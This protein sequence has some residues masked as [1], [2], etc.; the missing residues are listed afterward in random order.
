MTTA[1]NSAAVEPETEPKPLRIGELSELT[2]TTPRTIRYWE[3]LGLL[4]AG[5]DRAEGKH[6]SYSRADVQRVS[7][8]IRL[9]NLLGLSLEELSSL[10]E[11]E[12]ARAHLREELSHTESPAE[13]RRILE[14]LLGHIGG[15]LELVRRR[16]RE[17]DQLAGELEDKQRLVRRRLGETER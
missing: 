12:S 13:R 4:G 8:I 14:K 2:G 11:A 6:R 15:Q 10:L 9:R 3:E 5:S 7:E 1:S 17:L 16:R